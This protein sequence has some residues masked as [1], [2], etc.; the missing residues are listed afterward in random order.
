MKKQNMIILMMIM[1]LMMMMKQS[2]IRDTTTSSA[3]I[4]SPAPTPIA[5]VHPSRAKPEVERAKKLLCGNL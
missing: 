4:P 3:L 2:H 1:I 5:P